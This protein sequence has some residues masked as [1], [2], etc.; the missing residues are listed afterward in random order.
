MKILFFTGSRGEWGYIRPILKHCKKLKIKTEICVSNMH[1][2]PAFGSSINEIEKDNF[3]VNY[4]IYMALD[5]YN[6]LTMSK[7][8]GIFLQSFTDVLQNSKPDWLLLAGDRGETFMASVAGAYTNTPTAHIQAGELSGNIDGLARHA[9]GKMAHVHFASNQDAAKRLIRLGEE[10]KR[11]YKV[12]A[13]QLDE[14]KDKSFTDKN[15]IRKKFNIKENE[16]LIIAIFHPVTE[17]QKETNLNTIRIIKALE[18]NRCK[19]I[20]I[21]P[22]NDSGSDN[23]REDIL[24]NKNSEISFYRNLSREDFLGLL[25]VASCMIGNSSSALIEAPSFQ[26]PAINI[27]R[28]Q[29]N[30]ICGKNVITL[31]KVSVNQIDKLIKKIVFSDKNFLNKNISNPYGDGNSSL[32][33]I[34]ILK[35]LQSDRHLIKK[36]LNL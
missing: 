18:K 22:N 11:I 16:K 30:R 5:G 28:R 33:I 20:W 2:L 36:T 29:K 21:M 35:K 3:K 26:L 23:I 8:L 13:T 34:K 9:I 15:Q 14:I 12:G 27:G 25:S 31:E 32:K 10:K 7:S 4:K 19:K 6:D 24:N 17:D 1:L